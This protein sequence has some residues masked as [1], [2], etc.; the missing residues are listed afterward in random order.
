MIEED[1][2]APRSKVP[3]KRDL[4]PLSLAELE[5]YIAEME[6]EILRVREAI[7]AKR[8]QRGGAESLFKR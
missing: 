7:A 3:K 5:A 4:T 2:L 6:A 1:D 8:H